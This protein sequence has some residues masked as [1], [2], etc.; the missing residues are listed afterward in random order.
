MEN[1]LKQVAIS[2]LEKYHE[3]ISQLHVVFPNRR[4]GVFFSN[5]LSSMVT[6]PLISPEILTINELFSKSSHYQVPDEL[7]L[8]FRLYKVYKDL[9]GSK[10]SFDDFYSWGIMLI[11]DYDQ[12][13]KFLIYAKD[14]FANIT[15]LKEIDS[16]FNL[17]ET[18]NKQLL[19]NFWKTL[20]DKNKSDN[21]QEFISLWK[22]LA[23]IYENFRASLHKDGL[24]YEGMLY[25]N[26]VE[27]IILQKSSLLN[28]DQ[29]VF[30]GFNALNRCEEYLFEYLAK[31]G[32]AIFFWDY[33]NYYFSDKQ[34]EAGLFLRKN[35]ARFKQQTI[36]PSGDLSASSSKTMRI[37]NIASQS[38]QAQV[39]AEELSRMCNS[40]SK[41]GFDHTAV[42]LC[43]EELLLP[44]ISA[45][46]ETIDRVNITMGFPMKLTPVFAFFSLI[47][48]LQNNRRNNSEETVFYY[49]NVLSLLNHQLVAPVEPVDSGELTDFIST[50]NLVYLSSKLLAKNNLFRLIFSFPE[51]NC[52]LLDYLL[53]IIKMVYSFWEKDDNRENSLLYREYLYR[54]NLAVINL[55]EIIANESSKFQSGDNALSVRTLFRI[56]LQ[57][58]T[59]ISVPFEGEPLEGLQVMGILETRSLDFKNLIMV[60]VNDGIIPK[61]NMSGS[62]I[63]YN[64]RRAFGLP[65]IEEQNAIYAYYFY[66]LLQRAGDVTFIYNSASDGL[67]TGEK[68][69]YLYQLQME[70]PID[71]SEKT[72]TFKMS[73]A[74]V[75]PITICKDKKVV[76]LL[77]KYMNGRG[78]LSPTALDN[79]LTCSLRFYFSYVAELKEPEEVSEEVDAALFGL[80]FHDSMERIYRPLTGELIN[81]E[82]IDSIIGSTDKIE[83]SILDSFREVYFKGIGEGEKI[84]IQGK[85][86]LV[87]EIVKKYILRILY[88]DCQRSPFKIE[89]LEKKVNTEIQ[90]NDPKLK[91]AIGG[92]IDRI[93]RFRDYL[94]ILDYKTGKAELSFPTLSSLFEKESK[95]RNK[96]AFQTLVYSY[97][98]HKIQPGEISINPGIYYL[99]GIFEDEYDV[100]LKC[101]E[102]GNLPVESISMET[103]FESQFVQLLREIFNADI[104]FEQTAI[105]ENCRYC[106]YKQICR[107]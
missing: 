84:E 104:P 70:S 78:A 26:V 51:S 59:D 77:D 49:K 14:L 72:V 58:L 48:D 11:N 18:D 96:A 86:W 83:K 45:L 94:Q 76:S 46:P 29:Y 40:E 57:Y 91:V 92:T 37:M 6:K 28:E 21:Q 103:E 56:L 15:D 7:S 62:F 100:S 71:I 67:V 31:S 36:I 23:G 20:S 65:T 55:K 32:N 79:Y 50:N 38:G 73:G 64:L 24:A 9:T 75:K 69:R 13:D 12:V 33:D 82:K 61:I 42:V 101:R 81:S 10:E 27:E 41:I 66:R 43:D 93:D 2:L 98:L 1:F 8:V 47:S 89:G 106:P 60:S 63:P 88:L 107:R 39:V 22:D 52:G 68:S 19:E 80:L 4:S 105:E 102:K 17:L 35:L 74:K 95:S 3:N 30:V 54:S 97:I 99:R 85:N 53:E 34:Q 5:Y 87:F 16:R 44:V 90:I 25:R